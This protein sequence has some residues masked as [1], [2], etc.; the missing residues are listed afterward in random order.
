M[1]VVSVLGQALMVLGALVFVGA[2]V[3]L[4]RLRDVY[5]RGSAVATAAG[6]GVAMVTVGAVLLDP[7][8]STVIKVALAV[9]LQ[10]V[11]SALGAIVIARSAVLSGHPFVAG[12]DTEPLDPEERT[13]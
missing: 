13:P 7:D 10:L 5:A 4:W 1:S 6:L 2:A 12:T 3:G 8:V 11:T 9:V